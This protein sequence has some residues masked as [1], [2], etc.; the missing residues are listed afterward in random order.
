[1]E[2]RRRLQVRKAGGNRETEPLVCNAQLGVAAV[3]RVP[4]EAGELAE[5]LALG[6]AEA[7]GAARPAEPRHPDARARCEPSAARREHLADDLVTGD[8]R[9][10]G[11]GQ[12]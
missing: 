1:A 12:L 4:G 8:E 2:E 10:P 3:E 5:V 11:F 9:Q 7:A 6:A